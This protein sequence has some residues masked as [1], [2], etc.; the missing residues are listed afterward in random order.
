MPSLTTPLLGS[1]R[2]PTLIWPLEVPLV[3]RIPKTCYNAEEQPASS[4]DPLNYVPISPACLQI[5]SN[6]KVNRFYD[7]ITTPFISFSGVADQP[8]PAST[9]STLGDLPSYLQSHVVM[10]VSEA[11]MMMFSSSEPL[12]YDIM[13]TA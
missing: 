12:G 11:V 5:S 6:M 2:S 1:P 13:G 9:I 8:H 4:N 3:P 10:S 7:S